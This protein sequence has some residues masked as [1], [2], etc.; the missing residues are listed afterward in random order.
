MHVSV[1]IKRHLRFSLFSIFGRK[2]GNYSNLNFWSSAV[3]DTRFPHI[4]RNVP[5]VFWKNK[6]F[7]SFG[8]SP[9]E[10]QHK[11]PC[12]LRWCE[13]ANLLKR[14]HY[15][16]APKNPRPAISYSTNEWQFIVVEVLL[17]AKKGYLKEVTSNN[18]NRLL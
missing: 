15:R 17:L 18:S 8:N 11:R 10:Y 4:W 13:F 14:F 9:T 1:K 2:K 16:F 6:C 3:N 7:Q 5:S 12:I